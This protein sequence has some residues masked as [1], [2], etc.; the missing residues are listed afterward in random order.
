M[1]QKQF[2]NGIQ[3]LTEIRHRNIVK[4]YGFCSHT[5]HSFLVY[6]YLERGS[7]ATI[8]SN[9]ATAAELDWSTRVNVTK[10]VAH[11]L[12][13]MHR[14]CFPPIL[15]RDVSSKNVLLDLE[16]EA[17]VLDF[18]TAKLLKPD[19]CNWSHIRLCCTRYVI[20]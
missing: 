15:H 18:G 17:H 13:Y 4:F 20:H 19:S 9:E 12:S 7:L 2:V 3:A 14:D 6:E 8:L 10:G 1:H 16:Y 5:R 11:V